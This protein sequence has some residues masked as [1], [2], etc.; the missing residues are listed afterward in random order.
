MIDTSQATTQKEKVKIITDQLEKGI[1]ELM[2]SDKYME[3]L[4]KMSKLHNYS[5]RNTVLILMQ[6]PDATMVAS[7]TTWNKEFHRSVNKGEKGIT[8]LAP[9][10]FKKY[11]DKFVY[12][13]NGNIR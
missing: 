1:T 7:L 3:Y 8:I 10:R 5:F 13:D 4:Q 2:N 9:C 6:H 12:D 11:V